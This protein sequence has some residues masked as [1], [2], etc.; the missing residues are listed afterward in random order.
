M[1]NLTLILLFAA[2]TYP[3]VNAHAQMSP[4]ERGS[5]NISVE[6]HLPLGARMTVT[7]MELEQEMDRPY[8]YV[9]RASVLEDGPKG[10]DIIDLSD[11]KNPKRILEWRLDNQ[12]LHL[13]RGGMD[14]KYFKWKDGYYVV[15]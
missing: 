13:N 4:L 15:Q 14:V 6:G 11:P 7:D 9:G 8:A 1:K 10:M 5:D 2:C 12:D 3:A